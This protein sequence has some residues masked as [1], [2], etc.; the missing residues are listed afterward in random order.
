M[1]HLLQEHVSPRLLYR[2][3]E[4]FD[5]SIVRVGGIGRVPRSFHDPRKEFA[6]R[7]IIRT[8]QHSMNSCL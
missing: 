4:E 6:Q 1:N 2:L 7:M 5:L 3:G 8:Q